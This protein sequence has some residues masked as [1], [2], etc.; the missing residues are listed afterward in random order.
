VFLISTGASPDSSYLVDASA[1]GRDV[2]ISTREKLYPADKDDRFDVYDARVD[3]G[4]PYVEP[5]ICEGSCRGPGTG[6]GPTYLPGTSAFDAPPE[7]A[8]K[9]CRKGFVRKG[10]KCVKKSHKPRHHK[11]K[12]KSKKGHAK[13]RTHT[14]RRAAR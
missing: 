5:P 10:S 6:P 1:D 14:D 4:F 9:P 3:G 12:S 13:K 7:P 2:F 11:K 8:T